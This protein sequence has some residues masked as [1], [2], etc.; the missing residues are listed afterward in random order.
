MKNDTIKIKKDGIF[1]VEIEE[2]DGTTTG[3]YIEFDLESVELPL[4][5]QE[6]DELHKKNVNWLRQQVIAINK[7]EDHRGKKLLSAN[8]E[9]KVKALSEFYKKEEEALDK[10]LG[11][12]GTKK[13]L[14]GREAYYSMYDDINEMLEPI[15]PKLRECFISIE[16]KIKKKYSKKEDNILE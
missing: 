14:N 11:K 3:N 6:C 4:R 10:F 8:E 9:A 12:G 13:L 5:F 1:R 7:K 15:M 16:E 2:Y